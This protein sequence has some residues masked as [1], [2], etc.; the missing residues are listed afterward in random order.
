MFTDLVTAEKANDMMTTRQVAEV[1]GCDV[2]TINRN[3]KKCL[4]NKVIEHGKQTTFTKAEVTILI[5]YMKK[6]CNRNDLPTYATVAQVTTDMT[7]ALMLKQAMELADRAYK[8]E[9]ENLKA[10]N[11]EVVEENGKL[12]LEVK[13]LNHALEYD[14]VKGWP[15]WSDVKKELNL[16]YNFAWFASEYGLIEHEDFERKIMG[17]DKYPTI[18]INPESIRFLLEDK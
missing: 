18:L 2:S 14:K 16:C 6:N 3:F 7:P 12:R 8:M 5:D 1:L 17:W 15:R 10:K 4:P 13:Q 9:L 11:I